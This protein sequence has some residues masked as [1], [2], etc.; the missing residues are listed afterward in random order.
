M[1]R[2]RER[3]R[4]QAGREPTPSAGNTLSQSVRA[5]E[6]GGPHGYDGG[7]KLSGRKRH[8]LVDTTGLLLKVVV[9]VANIQDREGVKL[10]LEP[11][12][13]VFPRMRKDVAR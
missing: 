7:K 13:G 6:R 2:L 12:K 4:V 11:V 9:H 1:A 5:T 8:I 10:L 3:S